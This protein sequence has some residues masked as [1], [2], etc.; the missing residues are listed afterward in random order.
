MRYPI[1][2]QSFLKK[3]T[4]FL[5]G[6]SILFGPSYF[7]TTLVAQQSTPF[8]V[9]LPGFDWQCYLEIAHFTHLFFELQLV[10]E[11]FFKKY[12]IPQR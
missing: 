7:E 12:S 6:T 9:N 10:L 5:S 4:A 3:K 2:K 8:W 1:K 11:C